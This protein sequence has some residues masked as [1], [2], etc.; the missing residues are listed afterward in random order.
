MIKKN[1]KNFKRST[2]CWICKKEVIKVKANS[3]ITGKYRDPAHEQCNLN[4]SLTKKIPIVTVTGLEP[5]I[6]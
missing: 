1:H 5:T 3:H 6:T 4:L 2:K